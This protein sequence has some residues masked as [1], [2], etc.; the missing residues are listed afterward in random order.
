MYKKMIFTMVVSLFAIIPIHAQTDAVPIPPPE[1]GDVCADRA[2]ITNNRPTREGF[3]QFIDDIGKG[4]GFSTTILPDSDNIELLGSHTFGVPEEESSD[5]TILL[6]S[7]EPERP[8]RFWVMDNEQ[9][10]QL[11]EDTPYQDIVITPDAIYDFEVNLP[12]LD[13]GIHDIIVMYN[14]EFETP[15]RNIGSIGNYHVR[16]TVI[17]GDVDPYDTTLTYET[18]PVDGRISEGNYA[19]FS[20][21][22]N[23]S[24]VLWSAPEDRHIIAVGK[25]LTFNILS[26]FVNPSS[27]NGEA[28]YEPTI[29]QFAHVILKEYVQNPVLPD[30][31]VLYTQVGNDTA[32]NRI[33]ISLPASDEE[34]VYE[35][36][37]IRIPNPRV[38]M[39]LLRGDNYSLYYDIDFIRA[40]VE[41]SSSSSD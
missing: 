26:G 35:I 23:D 24:L 2:F 21:T 22:V 10:M 29:A 12:P 17:V 20:L 14:D 6:S 5:F 38:P 32:F 31:D 18:L 41:V 36:Q 28:L 3:Q 27:Y 30:K 37:A 19:Q 15:A 33:P 1:N 11:T 25:P 7:G 4:S 13:T 9:Q 39:C 16:F 8:V 34:V 40:A